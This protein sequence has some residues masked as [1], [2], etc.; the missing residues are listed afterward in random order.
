MT[1]NLPVGWVALLVAVALA[2]VPSPG[3]APAQD[4]K[5][6]AARPADKSPADPLLDKLKNDLDR[7]LLEGALGPAQPPAGPARPVDPLD[8]EL[9]NQLESETASDDSDPFAP[10][11]KRMKSAQMRIAGND[12]GQGTQD[13]QERIVSDLDRLIEQLKKNARRNSGRSGQRSAQSGRRTQ[14]SQEQGGSPQGGEGGE[15]QTAQQS[16]ADLRNMKPE[17]ADAARMMDLMRQVW[18]QLP[19]RERE[20]LQQLSSEKLL[21]KYELLIEKYFKKLAEPEAQRP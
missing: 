4:A 18:G 17:E 7:E 13:L 11:V 21:P 20:E 9:M 3:A 1:R 8:E 10:I 19:D 6:A 5:P 16:S 14:T 12:S 15:S 2:S